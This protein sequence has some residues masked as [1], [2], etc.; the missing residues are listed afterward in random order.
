MKTNIIIGH[1]DNVNPNVE[2]VVTNIYVGADEP[3]EE[4]K[5][6][7]IAEIKSKICDLR[8]S[9]EEL[10]DECFNLWKET[11]D[12]RTESIA[13]YL[14][15]ELTTITSHLADLEDTEEEDTEA[16]EQMPW[17]VCH[18]DEWWEDL[19]TLDKSEL[20]NIPFPSSDDGGRG[21]NQY[22]FDERVSKWWN[23]RTLEQKGEIYKDYCERY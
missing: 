16:D 22:E 6:M 23:S 17:D 10:S 19:D 14:H 1:V 5:P 8:C 20:A 12:K 9:I 11:E 3:K 2:K 18:L 4:T 21:D 15:Y 7:S 13:D